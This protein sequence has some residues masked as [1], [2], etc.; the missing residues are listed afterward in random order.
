M[1]EG[2]G[3]PLRQGMAFSVE[4]GIYLA[5][6]YGSRIE[7][8]VICGPAGPDP[9]ERIQSRPLGGAGLNGRLRVSSPSGACPIAS[10]Q[11]SPM[12]NLKRCCTAARAPS[13]A[14]MVAL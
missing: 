7:D 12:F 9:A 5:G 8:I 14:A 11:S 4:P 10:N 13:N 2:H 6:R 3:E 1:V